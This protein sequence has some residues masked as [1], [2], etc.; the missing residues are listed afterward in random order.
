MI[1]NENTEGQTLAILR[2]LKIVS[3]KK[4]SVAIEGYETSI[5]RHARKR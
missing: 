4:Q 5:F 3:K 2:Q 1:L